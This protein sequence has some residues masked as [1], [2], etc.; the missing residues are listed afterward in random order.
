[1]AKPVLVVGG[2]I[3]GIQASLDL[4]DQGIKVYLIEKRPSIG[5]RMAQLDKTFP[6]LDCSSCILTPKMVSVGRHTNVKLLTYSEVKEVKG[7]AG[8]FAVKVLKKPRYVDETKCTGDGICVQKCPFKG[9]SEFDMGLGA[10]K[11]IYFEFPQAVPLIPVIDREACAYFQKGICRVCEKFC[12]TAAIDFNQQP[13]EIELNVASIIVATG[14][15]LEDP[16]KKESY[17]YGRYANLYTNLEFERLLSSTGPTKGEVVRRSDKK[18]PKSIAFIQCVCSRD[19]LTNFYCSAFCCMASTKEAILAKEHMPEVECTIFYM[20]IRAFGKGYQE[21]Y[22]RA[23]KEFGV[24]YI[25]GRPAKIEESPQT[26]NLII[27]YEET[28]TGVLKKMEAEM[29]VLAVAAKMQPAAPAIPLPIDEDRFVK[30]KEPYLNP[31]ETEIEGVYVAGLAAGPK[32]IPDSV[33]QA[34]AAA[35]KAAMWARRGTA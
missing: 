27:H 31:V 19:L 6:T 9:V 34:S 15:E 21:F 2:G 14:F 5:G 8:N 13:K 3:A 4:A 28:E 1:M 18:H 29:V 24:R 10:R 20:D 26:K 22:E 30:L 12:P 35:V 17:G 16:K 7:S 23:R 11:A 25:R 32:D 33:A